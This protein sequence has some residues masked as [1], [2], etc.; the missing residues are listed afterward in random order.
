LTLDAGNPGATFL[1]SNSQTTQT[2][3]VTGLGTYSVT[4]TNGNGCSGTDQVSV[5][6][7]NTITPS[8]TAAGP[9]AFC[10][11]SSVTLDAG[12]GYTSYQWSTGA[13]SQTVTVST[14]QTVTVQVT[15]TNGCTGTSAPVTT[16]VLQL[17]NAA[18]NANGPTALCPGADVTLIAVNSFANYVWNPNG[19][20][21]QFITVTQ[22]GSYTVTVTDPNNGCTRTS[23]PIVVTSVTPQVPVITPN[24]DLEFCH[25]GSVVLNA[26]IGFSSY[27]WTTGSTTQSITVTQSGDYGITVMDAN[28][29]VDSTYV[30]NPVTVTVWQPVPIVQEV[31]GTDLVVTNGPFTTYQWFRNGVPVPGATSATLVPQQSG[32]YTVQVTDENGC[33]GNSTNIEFTYIGIEEAEAG[34]H[35]EL[36]PNP[37][38][39]TVTLEVETE[40]GM[41][42]TLALRDVLG[43]D[44]MKPELVKDSHAVRRQF[45]LTG[46]DKGVYQLMMIS[47][48]STVVRKLIRE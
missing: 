20:V 43:R 48:R 11:G 22:P 37:T 1:W 5:S 32:N 25:G 42:F 4:V 45:D 24:G 23:N 40:S 35:V 34:W 3:T 36:Y 14:A 10:S 33:Q 38:R 6:E 31:N 21:T 30:L 41:S 27:L 39:G 26:G 15:N 13:T 8:I 28:G 46:F 44:L 9:L 2:I 19:E 16:T 12:A 7:S 29:C 18:V 17:P 47:E